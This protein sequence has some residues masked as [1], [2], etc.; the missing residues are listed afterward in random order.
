MVFTETIL[1]ENIPIS[2]NTIFTI[3]V[4]KSVSENR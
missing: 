3:K 1:L 2:L 4:Q